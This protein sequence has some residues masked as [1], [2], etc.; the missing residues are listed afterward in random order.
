[1]RFVA[2]GRD[3]S[4]RFRASRR[5]AAQG[6][7]VMYDRYPLD[8]LRIGNRMV[9]GPRI[10]ARSNGQATTTARLA[11]TEA[12]LYH[13]ILPPEHVFVLHVS[14]DVSQQRKPEH[15]RELIEAKSEATAQMAR[16]GIDV[17]DIDAAQPLDDV[18]LQ[19]KTAVWRL[20]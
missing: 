18:L 12:Q 13:N 10:A 14:P 5:K 4:R 6:A 15:K 17:I 3:R 11:Q 2:E 19:V 9:D 20:L 1:M 8:A 7:I 16:A